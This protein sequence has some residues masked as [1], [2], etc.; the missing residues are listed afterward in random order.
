MTLGYSRPIA[1]VP[2]ERRAGLVAYV[3]CGVIAS[4]G[5]ALAAAEQVSPVLLAVGLAT[6]L[7]VVALVF[8]LFESSRR[9]FTYARWRDVMP[10]HLSV[11]DENLRIIDVNDLFRRDFGDRRGEYCYRVYKNNDRPCP[12]CPVVRTF[13]DGQVHTSEETVTTKDGAEEYVVVTSAPLF[14]DSGKVRAVVEMSTNITELKHLQDLLERTQRNY[15]RLF[16]QVPCYISVVNRDL[17]VVQSNALYRRDFGE[18]ANAY[19]FKLCKGRSTP[20]SDCLLVESFKDGKVHSREET[21][22]TRDRRKIAVVVY[23]MPVRSEEDEI[24]SVVEMFTDIT[25]VKRLQK[26]LTL[27]GRAVA[28]MAH[29]IK[30]ILM[31]LEGGMFVVN[32]GMEEN[33]KAQLA[34][35]WEMVERNVKRVSS[36]VKDLL[37]CAKER[38]P[39]FQE[40]VSPQ[41]IMKEVYQLYSRRTDGEAIALRLEETNSVHRATFDPEGVHNLLCNLV[42]NAIDG[43][44]FDPDQTKTTHN[45]TMRCRQDEGGATVLEVEDDGVG[46]PDELS[47]KVFEDF[48]STK[49]TEGTGVGLLVVQKVAEEHGGSVTFTTAPGKGTAFRVTLPPVMPAKQR[50]GS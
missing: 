24:T 4:L 18:G 48:F 44:R 27:M 17:R 34:E 23:T 10:S 50:V 41:E 15:R 9:L 36:V 37:Y 40:N 30:N 28:G 6:Y 21:L 19:C 47:Q 16:D 49:G 32:T 3:A 5:L 35:G 20:C 31:G 43:C 38:Q 13:Q 1:T 42:A 2:V 39:R 33:D 46:I 8:F 12:E 25:E 29:R 45:I 26:Q 7:A 14:D 11:Q 22:T